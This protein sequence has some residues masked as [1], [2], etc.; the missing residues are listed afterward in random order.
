MKPLDAAAGAVALG[1]TLTGLLAAAVWVTIC[2][3][4]PAI[5]LWALASI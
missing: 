1:A 4:L 5:A 3:A 2:F